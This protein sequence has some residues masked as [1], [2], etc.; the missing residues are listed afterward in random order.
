MNNR[1]ARDSFIYIFFFTVCVYLLQNI[2]LCFMFYA[3]FCWFVINM[4]I[5]REWSVLVAGDECGY[6]CHFK[7]HN[8][9]TE[10]FIA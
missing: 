5:A 3:F 4:I 6:L 2:G 7:S 1:I 10:L 8:I 9:S